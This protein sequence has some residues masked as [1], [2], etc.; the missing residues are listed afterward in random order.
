MSE[1]QPGKE[2]QK[3]GCDHGRSGQLTFSSCS[4]EAMRR[5]SGRSMSANRTQKN[6]E[7]FGNQRYALLLQ[8]LGAPHVLCYWNH[9]F[10][11][12]KASRVVVQGR[13]LVQIP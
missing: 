13:V 11:H 7:R 3:A 1:G 8:L 2:R 6:G 10:K 5:A 9:H 4:Q 12:R